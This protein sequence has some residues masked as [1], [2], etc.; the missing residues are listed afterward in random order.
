MAK[1]GT[2]ALVAALLAILA[3]SVWLAVRTWIATSAS[4]MPASGYVFMGLGIVL[5]LVVG[6]GLM[7]MVFYSSRHGYDDIRYDG[8]YRPGDNH[9]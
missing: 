1:L 5:S 7:A 3:A 2:F 6:C 4:P 8:P 9:D